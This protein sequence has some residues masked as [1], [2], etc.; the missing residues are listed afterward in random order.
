MNV[1]GTAG[2][3]GRTA[4]TGQ[5]SDGRTAD[6]GRPA[7]R[8]GRPARLSRD[9]IVAAALDIV[10]RGGS[11]AL[12]MRRVADAL[13]CSPMSLYRH[14][15]DKEELLVLMLDRIVDGLPRPALPDDPRA[16]L[17]ALLRWQHEEL[18]ARPWIAQVLRRGDVMAPSIRWL[19]EEI[20]A[21]WQA[22]G[23]PLDRAATANRIVWNFLLGDLATRADPPRDRPSYQVGVPAGADS[24]TYPMLAALRPYWLAPDRRDRF[25]DDLV[26]LVD[27]LTAAAVREPPRPG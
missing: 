4:D 24:E 10:A 13:G 22:C 1:A 2:S 25:A 5:G 9:R 20:Y 19:L 6:T 15:R 8:R 14:V 3:D 12:S 7:A 21:A 16:R 18:V 27:A 17:L 26:T 11:E 23:L